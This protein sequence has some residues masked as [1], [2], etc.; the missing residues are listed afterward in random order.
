MGLKFL[1]CGVDLGNR[2][3]KDEHQEH[4]KD[5]DGVPILILK[6]IFSCLNKYKSK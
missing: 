1:G 5:E 6:Y 3:G 4:G 2:E